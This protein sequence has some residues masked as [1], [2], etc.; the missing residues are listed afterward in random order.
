MENFVKKMGWT[1][2]LTSVVFA[3]LGLIIY[4]N[5][6]TT[7]SIIT[8]VIG[9]IFILIGIPRVVSYFK[10]KGAMDV[11]NFELLFGIIAI[12]LGIVVIVCSSFIQ[13]ILRISIGAWILYSGAIR[14][15]GAF[16]LRGINVSEYVWVT[17]LLLAIIMLIFGIYII[18]VP[19]SVI[20]IIGILMVIYSIM[21]IIEEFIF[22]KNL[23]NLE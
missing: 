15:G 16:K 14:L 20:S 4:F 1:S 17:V 13:A 2:V 19:G 9:A 6:N 18:A 5:P 22:M 8:Y 7:F 23:K 12:L 10:A 21:D 11:D 3:I